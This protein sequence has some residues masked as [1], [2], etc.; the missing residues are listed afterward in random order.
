MNREKRER[1]KKEMRKVVRKMMRRNI[2]M[3]KTIKIN[4]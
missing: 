2:V 3:N 4:I 1:G